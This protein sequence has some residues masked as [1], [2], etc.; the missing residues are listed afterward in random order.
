ME[1]LRLDET[2]DVI[3]DGAGEL[4]LIDDIDE[5]AQSVRMALSTRLGE[6][7][8]NPAE[9]G[10]EYSTLETKQPDPEEIRLA[11]IET[12]SQE[13]RIREVTDIQIEFD[14]VRRKVEIDFTAT[15]TN[16]DTLEGGVEL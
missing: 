7:F 13:E 15:L 14:R 2:G 6:W 9:H 16:G 12:V 4:L 1:T 5:V 3:F 11:V 8:L 10:F